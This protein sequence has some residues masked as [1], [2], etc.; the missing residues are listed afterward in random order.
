MFGSVATATAPWPQQERDFGNQK[1]KYQTIHRYIRV[2]RIF[3]DTMIPKT[4]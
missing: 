1:S 4:G 2:A 3:L